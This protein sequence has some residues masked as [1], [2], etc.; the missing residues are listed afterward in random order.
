MTADE[1]SDEGTGNVVAKGLHV[2][3]NAR[4]QPHRQLAGGRSHQAREP[5][6]STEAEPVAGPGPRWILPM[7]HHEPRDDH[8]SLSRTFIDSDYRASAR[9]PITFPNQNKE[10]WWS[11]SLPRERMEAPASTCPIAAGNHASKNP[12]NP[13]FRPRVSMAYGHPTIPSFRPWARKSRG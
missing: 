3:H 2:G 13:R 8:V 6:L 4:P 5:S 7:F 11:L 12:G 10:K 9:D 1:A